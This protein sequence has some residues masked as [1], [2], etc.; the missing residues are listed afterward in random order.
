ME[1]LPASTTGPD[2]L[3]CSAS[4]RRASRRRLLFRR[5]GP[6][7]VWKST[8]SYNNCSHGNS[9]NRTAQEI[10][11]T[12]REAALRTPPTE[13]Q[14][15]HVEATA[16]EAL[17][18]ELKDIAERLELPSLRWKTL[19]SGVKSDILVQRVDTHAPELWVALQ[20]KSGTCG[21]TG[22]TKF[23]S[24]AGYVMPT[25]CLALHDGAIVER[26]LFPYT[27]TRK[28]VYI[29]SGWASRD[30]AV[31]AAKIT[32]EALLQYLLAVPASEQ[33]TRAFWIYGEGH[34][35]PLTARGLQ[36][37][38]FSELLLGHDV[39]APRSQNTA[40]SA[41][42]PL[43]DTRVAVSF[44]TATST[45]DGTGFFFGIGRHRDVSLYLV[46]FRDPQ[47]Q[48]ASLGVIPAS[49][50]PWKKKGS[51]YWSPTKP[52]AGT[53]NITTGEQLRAALR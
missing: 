26:L 14:K 33:R 40:L 41:H 22:F 50:V 13:R 6:G 20:I 38:Q 9:R 44:K 8:G 1:S 2:T 29:T 43:D 3:N 42:V 23:H 24:T 10:S 15:H 30:P 39:E 48:M 53:L 5:I 4:K 31:E 45:N 21:P 12:I 37:Q 51:Y 47:G 11:T 35:A 16:I 36:V 17:I 32:P 34:A 25:V 19:P 28:A 27:L 52:F 18:R 46:G 7:E 49:A